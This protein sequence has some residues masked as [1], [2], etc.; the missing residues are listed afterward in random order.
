[1]IQ[2]RENGTLR[3]VT[4]LGK[5][6]LFAVAVVSLLSPAAQADPFAEGVEFYQKRNFSRAAG[7]FETVLVR[8]P[9]QTN[10][11]YYAG[12][13]YQQMGNTP[14]A[15]EFYNK[16]VTRYPNSQAGRLAQQALRALG[17]GAQ[18]GGGG[19]SGAG[20]Y[21]SASSVRSYSGSSSASSGGD[22]EAGLPPQARLNFKNED[23]QHIVVAGQ[24]NGRA[25]DFVFDTGCDQTV[26]GMDDLV[27][28][29]LSKPSG[30]PSGKSIGIGNAVTDNWRISVTLRVGG[31]ERRNFPLLV[32]DR[33]GVPPLLGRNFYSPYQF[34]IDKTGGTINLVKNVT[35]TAQAGRHG[36][37]VSGSSGV[38]FRKLKG[39][40][41]LVTAEVNGRPIEMLF[42]TGAQGCLFSSHH[43]KQLGITIPDD[44]VDSVGRGVGGST[45]TKNFP[46][47]RIRL[48]SVEKSNF[49]IG[50]TEIPFGEPLLGQSF[51]GDCQYTIDDQASVIRIRR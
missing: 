35:A 51:F 2:K 34:T 47:S 24:V 37:Y 38:P 11:M 44:A 49:V 16:L 39:G 41:I 5:A 10:A 3:S 28:C 29:G 17:G 8:S 27:R 26:I 32:S 14:K 7:C 36:G 30:P 23:G 45:H 46:I 15:L 31:I 22:D 50:V 19:S 12:L 13:T 6:A 25:L 20:S 48:G 9:E 18:R 1:M 21:S 42:D 4:K 40:G 43:M 33:T